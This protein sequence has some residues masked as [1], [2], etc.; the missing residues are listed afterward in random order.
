MK[1]IPKKFVKNCDGVGDNTFI[2]VKKEGNVY[3]YRRERMDGTFK[4]YE[5]FISKFIAK[6][7]PLP[8]GAVEKEDRMAYPGAQSFG[9]NAY[10]CKTEDQA[11][12]RFE[13]LLKKAKDSQDAKEEAERTGKPNKGRRKAKAKPD[14]NPPKG[15][16]TM[17]FLIDVTGYNQ[18]QLYPIVKNWLA[19][20]KISVVGKQKPEGGKGKPALVY[21]SVV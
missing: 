8:G 7:T 15:K 1:D 14:V 4:S 12:T 20:N 11:E 13:Q 16:F 2:Q 17:K 19:D 10:D 9:K 6:G 21:E 5:V 3:M 18:P